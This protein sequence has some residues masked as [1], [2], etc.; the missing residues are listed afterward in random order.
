MTDIQGAI[1]MAQL[2]KLDGFIS[3]RAKWARYYIEQLGDIEWLRL[4][5]EPK[6]IKH[7]W[8]SFVA[9]CDPKKSPAPR[10]KIME[11]LHNRGISTRPGTHAVH[12]LK[13]YK[14]KFGIGANDFPDAQDFNNNTMA[15][16]LHNR[17]TKEDYEY[18]VETFHEL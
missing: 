11:Y 14:D 2:K 13:L 18:I 12:M 4:P 16:P 6:N 5:A 15:I 3:E 1:G 10:N 8:Q 9:Y 17:M 7:G